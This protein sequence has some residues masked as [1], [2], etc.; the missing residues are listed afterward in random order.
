MEE[1]VEGRPDFRR[2]AAV[3]AVIGAAVLLAVLPALLA[4]GA[5]TGQSIGLVGFLAGLAAVVGGVK[6]AAIAWGLAASVD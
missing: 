2:T 6:L 4:V 1:H 3:L 5:A